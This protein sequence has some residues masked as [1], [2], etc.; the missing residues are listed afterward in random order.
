MRHHA[1]EREARRHQGDDV[2]VSKEPSWR[3]VLQPQPPSLMM[4]GGSKQTSRWAF[5][6]SLIPTKLSAKY[7]GHWKR[8]RLGRVGY[9][10]IDHCNR[11]HLPKMLILIVASIFPHQGL[12][13]VVLFFFFPS[14]WDAV[15][16]MLLP[17][18]FVWPGPSKCSGGTTNTS[19]LER[20]SLT[21]LSEV[22][23]PDTHSPSL[24]LSQHPGEIPSLPRFFPS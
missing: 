17:G 20:A 11:I 5:P 16:L 19:S 7:T 9:A 21:T 6:K 18:M 22:C 10:V 4:P 8:L 12:Y 24:P 1:G 3:Q 2:W 14:A 13:T 15:L 23:A